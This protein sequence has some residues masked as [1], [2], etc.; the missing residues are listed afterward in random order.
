MGVVGIVVVGMYMAV[1][2][3]GSFLVGED[4]LWWADSAVTA[5]AVLVPKSERVHK[6]G[7]GTVA[8]GCS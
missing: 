6:K 4:G 1:A 3:N 8:Q 2:A 7:C 5:R